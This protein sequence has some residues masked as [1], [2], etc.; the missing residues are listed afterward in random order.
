MTPTHTRLRYGESGWSPVSI[1]VRIDTR[2]SWGSA[3]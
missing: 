2:K 3:I 1:P